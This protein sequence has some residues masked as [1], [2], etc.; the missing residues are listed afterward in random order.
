MTTNVLILAGH[1]PVL[2]TAIDHYPGN[3]GSENQD[4]TPPEDR[5]SEVM[6][7]QPG[8]HGMSYIT[9]T[10]ELRVTE[11]PAPPVEVAPPAPAP[12]L[13]EA[14]GAQQNATDGAAE[15]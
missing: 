9:S 7:V 13:A 5:E 15:E 11:L 2:V 12:V 3:P 8:T 6:T 14:E 10:R 1:W 4:P